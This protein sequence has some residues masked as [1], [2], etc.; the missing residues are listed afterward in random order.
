MQL[1]IQNVVIEHQTHHLI[2][3]MIGRKSDKKKPGKGGG[4]VLTP[5]GNYDYYDSDSDSNQKGTI[6]IF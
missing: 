1:L 6:H 2:P 4:F 5:F 3:Y